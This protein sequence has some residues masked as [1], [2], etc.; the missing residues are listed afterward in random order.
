MLAS[1]E[2]VGVIT[3]EAENL[4]V[5]TDNG[6]IWWNMHELTFIWFVQAPVFSSARSLWTAS[7]FALFR[8]RPDA[9]AWLIWDENPNPNKS[10]L[11]IC[12]IWQWG[13]PWPVVKRRAV[14]CCY[15][16]RANARVVF[17]R[18]C[19]FAY[20]KEPQRVFAT[21]KARCKALVEICKM[22]N[23]SKH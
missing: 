15:V 21:K 6:E 5:I 16:R 4:F 10:T 1:M 18:N 11:V 2:L 20:K 19:V 22:P 14:N 9:H 12:S 3:S 7:T 17:L 8:L 13:S 23:T